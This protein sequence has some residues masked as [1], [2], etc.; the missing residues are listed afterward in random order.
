MQE[1]TVVSLQDGTLVAADDSG[2]QYLIHLGSMPI[3]PTRRTLAPAGVRK[4]TPRQIQSYIRG[5]MS[6]ADVAELT[7]SDVADIER[8]EG[9]ILAEREFMVNTALGVAVHL[10]EGPERGHRTTFGAAIRERLEALHATGERWASWREP[11]GG[12]V[13]KLAFTVDEIDHDARWGFDPRRRTLEALNPEATAISQQDI[14]HGRGLIPRLRVVSPTEADTSR[15]DSAAF[16]F[17]NGS[18]GSPDGHPAKEAPRDQPVNPFPVEAIRH[19]PDRAATSRQTADLLAS[20]RKRRLAETDAGSFATERDEARAVHPSTG[21]TSTE[22]IAPDQETPGPA[23]EP[24]GKAEN[25][26][27]GSSG[28]RQRSSI[29]SW[30]EIVFGARTDDDPA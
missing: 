18:L 9:P 21:K 12:W 17:D 3:P 14:A 13:I 11:E 25:H 23:E 30:D 8:F 4:S 22:T 27:P 16:T 2:S 1:L 5:G 26:R 15:F 10:S 7:G 6:A 20:L 24:A 29:P 19:A 28:R